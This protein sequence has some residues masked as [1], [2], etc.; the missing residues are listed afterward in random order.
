[1]KTNIISC[2]QI[3]INSKAKSRT[4]DKS[5]VSRSP[6]QKRRRKRLPKKMMLSTM[7]A[8]VLRISL[9][10]EDLL[11]NQPRNDFQKFQ[12]IFLNI[13]PKELNFESLK[14]GH[15]RGTK[16]IMEMLPQRR[17]N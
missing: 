8:R 3:Q 2:T 11:G 16:C 6:K 14:K 1:M 4:R 5:V 7:V 12:N 10:F 9:R 15:R 17:A 13:K